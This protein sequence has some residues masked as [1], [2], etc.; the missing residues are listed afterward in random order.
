M[1]SIAECRLLAKNPVKL[2]GSFRLPAPARRVTANRVEIC[3]AKKLRLQSDVYFLKAITM[4]DR[5]AHVLFR[6]LV[7]VLMIAISTHAAAP[8]KS[9]ERGRGS[10]FSY[11]T[12]DVAVLGS[13]RQVEKATHPEPMPAEPP[14]DYIYDITR[15]GFPARPALF[16]PFEWSHAPPS[17]PVRI[18]PAQPRAPPS[19]CA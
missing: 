10:A 9:V 19:H 1:G 15:F 7:V 3:H 13:V 16:R 14:A 4:I 11:A 2:S 18:R 12:V 8:A 17:E 5:I 6:M